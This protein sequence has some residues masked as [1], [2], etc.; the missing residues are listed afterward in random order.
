LGTCLYTKFFFH[1]TPFW[2]LYDVKT[3][4][5]FLLNLNVYKSL[6]F[7]RRNGVVTFVTVWTDYLILS[8]SCLFASCF[9]LESMSDKFHV[10]FVMLF[11]RQSAIW[12]RTLFASYC[13]YKFLHTVTM[14]S[15]PF[16]IQRNGVERNGDDIREFW[17]NWFQLY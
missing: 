13:L 11:E 1:W 5:Q 7:M 15:T 6:L 17:Q 2:R 12:I 3:R 8:Y 10:K 16:L 9:L 4:L 14:L